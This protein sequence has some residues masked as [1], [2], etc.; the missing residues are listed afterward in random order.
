MLLAVGLL[1]A[2]VI[3]I[4]FSS[5][6]LD[7]VVVLQ[8]G[9]VQA[10]PAQDIVT[11]YVMG[12]VWAIGLT[13]GVFIWGTIVGLRGPL[14]IVW[15]AK[16]VVG[17]GLMLFYDYTYGVDPDGYFDNA[18][19]P[20]FTWQGLEIGRGTANTQMLTWLHFRWLSTSYSASR[21]TFSLIG[22]VGIYF[23]Y[24]AAVLCI[25][26]EDRRLFY[27]FAFIPS[28]LFWSSTLG[29]DPITFA[30][31][32]TYAYG[33][34][35]WHRRAHLSDLILI[36]IGVTI[37]VYIRVWLGPIL[38]IPL[39]A[40]GLT[41]S[42]G[43]G[44]STVFV[45]LM[46]LGLVGLPLVLERTLGVSLT[47]QDEIL[48][49][50]DTLSRALP[51]G[52]SSQEVPDLATVGDIAGFAPLGVFTA[53][54]RPLPGEVNNAFG[55]LAGLENVFFLLLAAR[56]VWRT[57]LRDLKEPL[58]VWAITAVLLWA[59]VYSLGAFQNL[60]SLSRYRLQIAPLFL[61]VLF[62]LGRKRER[63]GVQAF[64]PH[65]PYRPAMRPGM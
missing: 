38:L 11:D 36:A 61:G 45:V 33:V 9:P 18:S 23:L 52:G 34:V 15:S 60:G 1:L 20:G 2:T 56:A 40:L 22:L 41:R 13:A 42:Q 55:L 47:R 5:S 46:V 51:A 48:D 63:Q 8:S 50:V 49:S 62:Y 3:A 65:G 4:A 6:W 37:G 17:L 25:D 16:L 7:W 28:V 43:F 19:T 57:R 29:K 64:Q 24:R 31:I 44:R 21:M 10:L 26:R 35:A 27:L 39:A 32:A 30:G 59:A 14:L 53:L 58:V 12:V 54:F